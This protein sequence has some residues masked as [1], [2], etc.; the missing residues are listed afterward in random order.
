MS[1]YGPDLALVHHTGFAD[2]SEAAAPGLLAA[3]RRAGVRPARRPGRGATVVDLG[4]GGG[5]WLAALSHA[6][7]DAHGIE[8]SPALARLARRELARRGGLQDRSRARAHA[9]TEALAGA[10]GRGDA[11][12]RE[13]VRGRAFVRT[14]SIY[15]EP[16]PRCDAVTALGEV[17]GYLPS[18]GS[19]IPSFAVFFRR[20][21]RALRPGGLFVFD[22]I[23]R[24]PRSPLHTRNYRIGGEDERAAGSAAAPR[25]AVLAESIE[26]PRTGRLTRDITIFRRVGSEHAAGGDGGSR[27]GGTYSR[28]HELHHVRVPA[29]AEILRAL[30]ATGFTTRTSTRYGRMP[31]APHRLAF[32]AT[33]RR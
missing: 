7:Y 2:F 10:R 30:A 33:R 21:A 24:N 17:L 5:Q 29:R 22:L 13:D 23:V 8:L 9:H 15:T 4:C 3:L 27:S 25:W 19:R 20:V 6:G 18:N 11:R 32:F 28:S 31:L 14:G 26:S 16:L 1:F 12:S